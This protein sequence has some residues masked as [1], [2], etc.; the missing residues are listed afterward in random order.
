MV[1]R[2]NRRGYLKRL[3]SEKEEVDE[4]AIFDYLR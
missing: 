3:S 1:L 4:K 2:E